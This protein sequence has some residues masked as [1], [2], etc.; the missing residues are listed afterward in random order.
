MIFLPMVTRKFPGNY[1]IIYWEL[2]FN[3]YTVKL[4]FIDIV[5][6]IYQVTCH[7]A[8]WL[9]AQR[10]DD[11]N[12]PNNKS[13]LGLWFFLLKIPFGKRHQPRLPRSHA[14]GMNARA[15]QGQNFGKK[16]HF[17]LNIISSIHKTNVYEVLFYWLVISG[18]LYGGISHNFD[19]M[20]VKSSI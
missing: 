9:M 4:Y 1:L 5:Q 3:D 11:E 15:K 8:W 17:C 16:S 7:Y 6:I 14:T 13:L 10:S 2:L 18:Q 19:T 12:V 20:N